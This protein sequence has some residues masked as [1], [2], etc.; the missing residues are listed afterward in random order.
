MERI[1]NV[2]VRRTQKDYSMSFKLSVVREYET[3]NISLG[4]LRRKYGIQGNATI[5]CWIEKFGIFDP[6][7][8]TPCLMSKTKDQ[9]VLE[10]KERIKMLERKNARLE[11][12]LECQ[13]H[14]AAF[15][16]LMIDVAEEDLGIK[17]RKKVLPDQFKNTQK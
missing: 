4:A 14:K 2:Y 16:D 12:E 6:D 17:I 15:F 7:N 1:K 8:Q 5:R 3:T 10:L 9:E 13:C 11:H